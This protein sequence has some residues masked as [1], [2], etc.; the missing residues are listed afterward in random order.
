M[1]KFKK[2]N[3]R[4]LLVAVITLIL[5]LP[6][7]ALATLPT[8]PGQILKKPNSTIS[9][10]PQS[11]SNNGQDEDPF[12]YTR[13]ARKGEEEPNN[14][15]GNATPATWS[16]D[17]S[18]SGEISSEND[19]D[20]FMMRLRVY[21]DDN[22]GVLDRVDR[23]QITPTTLTGD[24]G[25][26]L[27]VFIYGGFDI[28]QNGWID[29][30][31]ELVL[32]NFTVFEIGQTTGSIGI[33]AFHSKHY[34]YF[35]IET[36]GGRANYGLRVQINPT[37]LV[38]DTNQYIESASGFIAPVVHSVKMS[39]DAF[40]WFK[41][42]KKISGV[43]VNFTVN[44]DINSGGYYTKQSVTLENGT[45][46]Y[47]VTILHMLV[48]HEGL[49]VGNKPVFPYQYRDHVLT[50]KQIQ[51]NLPKEILYSDVITLP[52]E[53]FRYTYIGFFVESYGI[54]LT[55][56]GIKFYPLIPEMEDFVQNTYCTFTIKEKE[57]STIERPEL[58]KVRV[59][60]TTTKR[61]YGRTT[62]T[63]KYSVVYK[64]MDNNKP[65]VTKISV[66]S[67]EGEIIND[68]KKITPGTV[69]D[70]IYEKGCM[71]EFTMSGLELGEGDYHVFQFHFKDEHTWAKGT[72]ELGKSWHGPYIS[73]NIE[74]YVRPSAPKNVTLYED[75]NT[76]F[77]S[78]NK[79]FEDVDLKETLNYT[80]A[81]PEDDKENIVWGKEL[82]NSILDVSIDNQ[83]RLRIDPKPNMNGEVKILLN[84]SDKKGYYLE[85]NYKF[86][87][88]VLPV[89]D[90]PQVIQYFSG[91]RIKED[92]IHTDINLGEHFIDLIDN[93]QLEYRVENNENIDVDIEKNGNVKIKPKLNWFG[94]EFIDFY[95]S[96][97]DE[98][99]SDF[100]KIV[101]R[102]V[103]DEPNLII[104]DT[105]EI[106]EDAWF[107]I[108]IN[109][110][111]IADNETV[112]IG[113][114]LTDIFPQ[115][116]SSP[117]RHGYSFDNFTGYLTF[118]PTNIMV[119]TYSWNISAVDENN[120]LNFT[121]VELTITNIN[122]PPVVEI[123][124]PD[125]GSRYL[126]TDK[127]GFRGTGYDADTNLKD[128]NF[129]WY[130]LLDGVLSKIG[131]GRVLSPQLFANGTHKIILS[132][133]DG[134]FQRNSSILIKVF[135]INQNQDTD[136]DDIPDYWENIY[137]FNINDPHDAE[138]DA[139]KDTFSNWEEFKA[140]TDPR[141][142]DFFPDE[143]ITRE[144]K[145]ASEDYSMSIGIFSV[146]IVIL[147]LIFLYMFYQSRSKKRKEKE[148]EKTKT[149]GIVGM[150]SGTGRF[151]PTGN[152]KLKESK[153]ICNKC[154]K[155]MDI[156]TLNRP[157]VVTCTDCGTRG[158]VYK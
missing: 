56:P 128:P 31:S 7:I 151:T 41:E 129:I 101:V 93:D 33:N 141:D 127:I 91:L 99:V 53:P 42:D 104:N 69:A 47:F 115:L 145:E 149:D 120:V 71:Y 111:D 138:D 38:D 134:E 26:N 123:T 131:S 142:A 137:Y 5:I 109:A 18:F 13:G 21:D 90:P 28:N 68:M 140:E 36:D 124:Y 95:A 58:S 27:G 55:R 15:F 39:D 17:T 117:I 10:N 133:D 121:H 65:L 23:L 136:G 19:R 60:S 45:T 146:L 30:E 110:S 1:R 74:P 102:P 150:A 147:I 80:L 132:V 75:D 155:S 152:G 76:T 59:Y 29:S 157:V 143:H 24:I 49:E 8:E 14:R 43:G 97:G 73:N 70:K 11:T 82:S 130:S 118:K 119:G 88:I 86:S 46:I 40:D 48:Y 79:I 20:W 96:D 81:D 85:E 144:Q 154:G 114:N 126:T 66:F 3:P 98:E 22:N 52:T 105:I 84:V 2:R 112:V 135:R 72:I 158:V 67:L 116:L 83:S 103:N 77:F 12:F 51:A 125:S 9:E 94:T 106:W 122:D 63:Y 61:V 108:T 44:V 78:L 34:Y 153:I 35:K 57:V 50:S 92:S 37:I 54:D 62:D 139:D 25:Y 4:M 6:A 64:Q 113:H 156:L 16:Q 87:I 100:L 148:S 107:N 32:M 89:N